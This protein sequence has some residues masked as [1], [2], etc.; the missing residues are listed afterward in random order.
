MAP[1]NPLIISSSMICLLPGLYHFQTLFGVDKY[2]FIVVGQSKCFPV[3][4]GILHSKV[5]SYQFGYD[6]HVAVSFLSN[7][8]YRLPVL[9]ATLN[10]L[11][12]ARVELV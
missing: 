3:P 1:S 10:E 7:T 9:P 6:A 12:L 5:I 8:G 4:C 2:I 11:Y